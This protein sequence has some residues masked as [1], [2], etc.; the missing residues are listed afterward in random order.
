[1][2]S[3]NPDTLF[4]TATGDDINVMAAAVETADADMS[5]SEERVRVWFEK[6][7]L[8]GEHIWASLCRLRANGLIR[9]ADGDGWYLLTAEGANRYYDYLG[10]DDAE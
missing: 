5:F 1:M 9:P 6:H 3:R 7:G 2:N 8:D 10:E 4:Y